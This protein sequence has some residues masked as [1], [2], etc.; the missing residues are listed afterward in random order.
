MAHSPRFPG[1]TLPFAI[2]GAPAL[3][4]AAALA[5]A[6]I[7]AAANIA[8]RQPGAVARYREIRCAAGE[9][10][11]CFATASAEIDRHEGS[12]ESVLRYFEHT[13]DSGDGDTCLSL[14]RLWR[15]ED[16]AG[17]PRDVAMASLYEYRAAQRGVCPEGQR[18]VT[19]AENVCVLPGDPR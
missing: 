11:S 15:G 14:S 13:C 18:L 5:L 4:G 1:L 8:A 17:E 7:V 2:S 6:S 10:A 19:G 12:P 16:R 3:L 9:E